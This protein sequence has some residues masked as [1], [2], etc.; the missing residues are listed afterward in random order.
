MEVLWAPATGSVGYKG[1]AVSLS[2]K[3]KLGN[4]D[5]LGEHTN[6]I[7]LVFDK[8]SIQTPE[9]KT[10][11]YRFQRGVLEVSENNVRVFLGI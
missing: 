6:L 7:S 11:E 4:F 10:I 5:V 2:S 3:N 9:K 8:L 1:P